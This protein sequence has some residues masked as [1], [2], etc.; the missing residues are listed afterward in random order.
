MAFDRACAS[1]DAALNGPLR[2]RIVAEVAVSKNFGVALS[3]L[4]EGMRAN[5]WKSGAESLDLSVVVE[6]LDA[7][8]R[9]DG[10]HVLHDWD[11]QADSVSDDTIPVDVLNYLVRQRGAEPPDPNAL[12]IVLD[13]YFLHVLA[14]L[15]LRVWDEGDADQNVGRLS[16]LLDALHGP[17]GSGQ[18]FVANAETLMLIAT[19]HFE[20]VERGYDRLLARVRTLNR[21]HRT[22]IA[23]GHAVSMGAHLRFGFQ[24]T[25][26]RDTVV[27]RN[28]NV[29]DYP[30]LCFAL[31]TVMEEYERLE[32]EGSHGAASDLVVEALLCGLSPDARAFVGEPPAA[33][34]ACEAERSAF[35]ARFLVHRQA[36]LDAF[37]R[38]RPSDRVYSPLSFF[39]NFSH[40]VLKGTV[41]DALLR[42]NAWPLSFN[43]LL[44]GLPRDALVSAS[45]ESLA[46][47]LMGYARS[48]PDTIRGRLTPVIV[49]DPAA[50][51]EAFGVTLRKLRE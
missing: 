34:A 31:A 44:T 50:G 21:A 25:Y 3:R 9:Q 23:L 4:R 37:E 18:R 6:E 48:S 28:D 10:F 5:A 19:S 39:F 33:L 27:M 47:T 43:D 38:Y 16:H 22:N 12:A 41:V 49:Y 30:W 17:Q 20:V 11:G 40:N 15:S 26:A 45:K 24:A 35:R 2:R 14:L 7:R 42:G 13:Y 1:L 29:A 46:E 8:T 36:L 51:L 32:D